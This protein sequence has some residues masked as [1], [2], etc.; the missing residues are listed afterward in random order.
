VRFNN[1]LNLELVGR[2]DQQVNIR[3][4]RVELGGIE[5]CMEGL[6]GI[7]R[8]AARIWQAGDQQI[9]CAYYVPESS[10]TVST[11]EIRKALRAELPDYMV[12]QYFF[13]L[14]AMPLTS[15]GKIDRT[16][17]PYPAELEPEVRSGTEPATPTESSIAGIWKSVLGIDTVYREDFFFDLGGHS[18]LAVSVAA[19]IEEHLG[20][21][22][23][24]RTLVFS[25]LKS[26]A[27]T[28]DRGAPPSYS[29]RFLTLL[30][31]RLA[32]SASRRS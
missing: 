17:L 14:A 25:D 18:L 28:C 26:I 10:A 1:A 24:F 30:K 4:F 23:P 20:V 9:L 12:P 15:A 31:R 22:V 27:E 29:N 8:C 2:E 6:A 19:R 21:N 5:A 16:A 3:G 7:E 13:Q 32:R 11:S